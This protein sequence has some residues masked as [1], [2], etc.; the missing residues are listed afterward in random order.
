M[1]I[2]YLFLF[3]PTQR[4]LTNCA[5]H[6][7]INTIASPKIET[8]PKSLRSSCFLPMRSISCRSLSVPGAGTSVE[9]SLLALSE[10]S[11]GRK[12]FSWDMMA[13][14]LL[15]S[16]RVNVWIALSFYVFIRGSAIRRKFMH[17]SN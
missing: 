15:Q 1:P 13:V 14:L 12:G 10:T 7:D 17:A 16:W 2:S 6:V 5:S 8:Y 3:T 9:V 11:V 4:Q